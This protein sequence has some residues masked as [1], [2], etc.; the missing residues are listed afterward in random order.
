MSRKSFAKG[1][2]VGVTTL[3]AFVVVIGGIT[4]VQDEE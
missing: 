1:T 3:S 4:Q 2:I